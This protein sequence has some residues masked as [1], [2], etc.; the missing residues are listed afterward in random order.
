MMWRTLISA[1][2][3]VVLCAAPAR[4][5]R[6]ILEFEGTALGPVSV[7]SAT[8]HMGVEGDRYDLYLRLR[9]GGVLRWFDRT[10]ISATAEGEI[11]NGQVV[12]R[13]YDLD[14]VY[15]AKRRVTNLRNLPEGVV[16]LVTPE[17][18]NLGKP[19]A[20]AEQKAASR[21]PMS[22]VAAMS[23]QV[24]R[25]GGC[26]GDFPV[27][28][29]RFHYRLEL[30]PEGPGT[31]RSEAYEGPVMKCKLR[32]V[33]VSGYDFGRENER[34]RVPQGEIWFAQIAGLPFA[35]PVK[36]NVPLPVGSA[37]LHLR[38][39]KKPTITMDTVDVEAPAPQ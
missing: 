13:R 16:A 1:A 39:M 35:P 21:D 22:A 29:G 36:M 34:R 30:R 8:L 33:Q 15:A 5:E 7:G 25:G 4:A 10:E 27:F 32:Y 28:D 12:W 23:V 6:Y 9:S 2:A 3:L 20:S 14:H 11:A 24:A 18:R 26:A 31:L 19:P 38:S 37:G 17:H